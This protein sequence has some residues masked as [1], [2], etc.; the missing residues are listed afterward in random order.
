MDWGFPELTLKS[1]WYKWRVTGPPP[2]GGW[3][4]K[5]LSG[6]GD[7]TVHWVDNPNWPL[8]CTAVWLTSQ[9]LWGSRCKGPW[10]LWMDKPC[11]FLMRKDPKWPSSHSV[12]SPHFR[13]GY[14]LHQSLA[15]PASREEASSEISTVVILKKKKM[16]IIESVS[17]PLTHLV[18]PRT[19]TSPIWYWTPPNHPLL[20]FWGCN[21][22]PEVICHA[23]FTPSVGS[24]ETFPSQD[25]TGF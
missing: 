11:C 24:L 16:T 1:I 7:Q 4:G 19:Y 21:T 22:E 10:A 8:V 15:T 5:S 6:D 2:N 23:S 9:P 3:N 17:G 13:T 18:M 12:T 25:T 20:V 14:R